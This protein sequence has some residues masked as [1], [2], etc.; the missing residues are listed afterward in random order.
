VRDPR[1]LRA[2]EVTTS[3]V[4]SAVPAAASVL[5]VSWAHPGFS[6]QQAT[7]QTTPANSQGVTLGD[8]VPTVRCSSCVVCLG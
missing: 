6:E 7:S 8:V 4:T 3:C 5:A 1:G 2:I